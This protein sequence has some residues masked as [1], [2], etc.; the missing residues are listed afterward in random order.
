MPSLKV[1]RTWEAL[2]INR[3]RFLKGTVTK[4]N[5]EDGTLNA[6]IE[7]GGWTGSPVFAPYENIVISYLCQESVNLN[8]KMS[9][10]FKKN[11]SVLIEWYGRDAP[12]G[13]ETGPEI[14]EIAPVIED[15]RV[16]GFSDNVPRLCSA[17]VI[18]IVYRAFVAFYDCASNS[19]YYPETWPT[20]MVKNTWEGGTGFNQ[21]IYF[22]LN[23]SWEMEDFIEI[24]FTST[25]INY[26]STASVTHLTSTIQNTA[27]VLGVDTAPCICG[28]MYKGSESAPPAPHETIRD[29]SRTACKYSEVTA[30]DDW[31]SSNITGSDTKWD[32]PC[33]QQPE[34]DQPTLSLERYSYDLIITYVG[35]GAIPPVIIGPPSVAAS[36]DPWLDTHVTYI[37]NAVDE[38]G[39]AWPSTFEPAWAWGEAGP[40]HTIKHCNS[41]TYPLDEPALPI[42]GQ[43]WFFAPQI[44]VC[45]GHAYYGQV[46]Y[47]GYAQNSIQY[48]YHG[49]TRNASLTGDFSDWRKHGLLDCGIN[50]SDP[51]FIAYPTWTGVP[52]PLPKVVHASESQVELNGAQ[53]INRSNG[54]AGLITG[55]KVGDSWNWGAG[56]GWSVDSGT[57]RRSWYPV[58]WRGE[59]YTYGQFIVYSQRLVAPATTPVLNPPDPYHPYWTWL[60]PQM[61]TVQISM[62]G[63]GHRT[64]RTMYYNLTSQGDEDTLEFEEDKVQ[65]TLHGSRCLHTPQTMTVRVYYD[66]DCSYHAPRYYDFPMGTEDAYEQWDH[67][68]ACGDWYCNFPHVLM[69]WNTAQEREHFSQ[70]VDKKVE[71]GSS[72]WLQGRL[73]PES[74]IAF[75]IQSEHGGVW[76]EDHEAFPLPIDYKVWFHSA[77]KPENS[78]EIEWAEDIVNLDTSE[79]ITAYFKKIM[80]SS[81]SSMRM[82]DWVEMSLSGDL[83]VY[84]NSD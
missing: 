74:L 68:S 1:N 49:I 67:G 42:P 58:S 38:W 7:Q 44:S 79:W 29:I 53:I 6:R 10:A 16:I 19:N 33:E 5:G 59:Y 72:S 60:M 45:A 32:P 24:I 8:Y 54:T 15:L 17:N 71:S 13:A 20:S 83:K 36:E 70:E 73:C 30:W 43:K 9:S 31:K 51:D 52:A 56:S 35:E 14:G 3:S 48:K 80:Y 27:S 77:S 28:D 18:A 75:E 81:T 50:T 47:R 25:N 22:E 82:K 23:N 40:S 21:W 62:Q 41:Y 39:G 64:K 12:I 2:G 76:R 11:D 84:Y 66:D 69:D 78:T 46:V 37:Q 26:S 65:K 61:E 57:F 55:A 34:I 4:I 63:F